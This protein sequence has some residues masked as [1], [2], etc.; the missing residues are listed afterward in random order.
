[1]L[2][3]YEESSN[4]EF[5]LVYLVSCCCEDSKPT[6]DRP[7]DDV[8]NDVTIFTADDAVL[9][10]GVVVTTEPIDDVQVFVSILAVVPLLLEFE[11]RTASLLVSV[12]D[13]CDAD[14]VD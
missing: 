13:H 3:K 11:K 1:L 9:F 4:I 2:L 5:E 8:C 10:R 14:D 6:D 12:D 7:A